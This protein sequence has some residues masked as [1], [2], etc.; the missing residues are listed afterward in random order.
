MTDKT[1]L[2]HYVPV[3]NMSRTH[4]QE[5][6]A[7]YSA[8][9]HINDDPEIIHYVIPSKDEH[10]IECL[11]PIPIDPTEYHNIRLMMDDIT[12]T[13]NEFIQTNE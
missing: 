5:I 8:M 1:I 4:A 9:V 7:Q 6:M 13:V 3:G 2:V 10:C 11:N 12:Q